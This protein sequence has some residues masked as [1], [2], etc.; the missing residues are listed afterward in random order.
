MAVARA[1]MALPVAVLLAC[2]ACR[3]EPEPR[4]PRFQALVD[5]LVDHMEAWQVPGFQ[6]VIIENGQ[7]AHSAAM[8]RA[9]SEPSNALVTESTRF[10]LG[11]VTKQFTGTAL[12]QLERKG[13][14]DMHAPI[15]TYLPDFALGDGLDPSQLTLHGLLTHSSGLSGV[16]DQDRCD[17]GDPGLGPYLDDKRD[18][19]LLFTDS[20][21][22]YNY[23]NRGYAIAGRVA[24]AVTGKSFDE[25]VRDEV[26]LPAGLGAMA[27]DAGLHPPSA[28]AVGHVYDRET[29]ELK[30]T[31]E[32]QGLCRGVWPPGGLV[33]SARDLAQWELVLLSEMNGRFDREIWEGLTGPQW[34]KSSS[35]H[36]GYGINVGDFY[37]LP[38][39]THSGSVS[40]FKTLMSVFPEHDFGIALTMNSYAYTSPVPVAGESATGFILE[41]AV[42]LFLEHDI[43]PSPPS[44]PDPED[45]P[46][47]VGEWTARYE[48][49]EVSTFL[50][51]DQLWISLS[52]PEPHETTMI[53]YTMSRWQYL[54]HRGSLEEL[55][56]TTGTDERDY[57]VDRGGVAQRV[58]E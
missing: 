58:D 34:Q 23:S 41:Q 5:Y 49:G 57:L 30:R 55:K 50:R 13:L 54:D 25:V 27:F 47:Y 6:V 2:S 14:V 53:P 32:L 28:V 17:D 11:S 33:G 4:D 10:R 29:R 8:G 36:Y 39:L 31:E 3:A 15:S 52:E 9:R 22:I 45:L 40:G 43:E 26:L 21:V 7:I 56:W 12:L 42:E 37:D 16:S 1:S 20:G 18:E 35:T 46:D 44:T 51:D 19:L 38:E 24:E 48:L